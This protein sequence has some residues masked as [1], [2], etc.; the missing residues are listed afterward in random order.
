MRRRSAAI[1]PLEMWPKPVRALDPPL[2]TESVET[3]EEDPERSQDRRLDQSVGPRR[4][5]HDLAR[6]VALNGPAVEAPGRVA[7]HRHDDREAEE[8]RQRAQ[9]E[10]RGDDQPPE[11]DSE[12]VGARE[13]RKSG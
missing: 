4:M 9:E 3:I 5:D 13:D 1:E 12:R 6:G 8:Q 10:R 11:R 7:E 2:F